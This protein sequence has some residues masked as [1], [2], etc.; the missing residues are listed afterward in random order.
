MRTDGN[1]EIKPIIKVFG[2]CSIS[3]KIT[4]IYGILCVLNWT[5]PCPEMD[6]IEAN[7]HMKLFSKIM[8]WVLNHQILQY[9]EDH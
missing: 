4:A 5:R 1:L 8:E 3:M 6:F 9:L 7:Y 2:P